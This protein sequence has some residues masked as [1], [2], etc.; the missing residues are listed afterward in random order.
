M[1]KW[2]CLTVGMTVGDPCQIRMW[3]LPA[4]T[5]SGKYLFGNGGKALVAFS[6][7]GLVKVATNQKD[8]EATI[9]TIGAAPP[10]MVRNAAKRG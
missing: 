2:M 4:T 7:D 10:Q 1:M 5:S 9:F 8:G 6:C 3:T